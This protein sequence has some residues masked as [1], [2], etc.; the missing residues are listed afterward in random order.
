MAPPSKSSPGL[1]A[2]I[3]VATM[4]LL[5]I[6]FQLLQS[7]NS[8]TVNE[9]SD[10]NVTSSI[11]ESDTTLAAA[12]TDKKESAVAIK[13]VAIQ[14]VAIQEVAPLALPQSVA[15]W[16]KMRREQVRKVWHDAYDRISV[17]R[18]ELMNRRQIYSYFPATY[19]C[20][21]NHFRRIGGSDDGGKW[22]CMEH[23]PMEDDC[24]VVSV[25]SN[26]QFEF[27]MDIIRASNAKCKIYTFDCTG[28]WTPPHANIN[29]LPWCLSSQDQVLEG[30]QYYTWSTMIKNLKLTHVDLFK[31]DIEGYEWNTLPYMLDTDEESLLPL[32]ILLE[33]HFFPQSFIMRRFPHFLNATNGTYQPPGTPK[34]MIASNGKDYLHPAIRL[35]EKFDKKG[36]QVASVEYNPQSVDECCQE[37]T[38]I[39]E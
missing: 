25:G 4:L 37:F 35:F 20:D 39:R 32:Q 15:D 5:M 17:R 31:M 3:T 28:T 16:N 22:I 1:M 14:K 2:T 26:G 27:E 21:K 12:S 9:S 7:E 10:V 6:T 38:F 19:E 18:G 36:F 23:F 34:D 11:L 13:E 30:R 24:V 29:L 33:L 8:I